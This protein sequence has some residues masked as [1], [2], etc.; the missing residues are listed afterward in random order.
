VTAL[1]SVVA[2]EADPMTA[3]VLSCTGLTTDGARNAII[4]GDPA[5]LASEDLGVLSA[6]VPGCFAVIGTEVE[7]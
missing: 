4:G 6:A 1:P 2:R 5:I 3:A 7:G